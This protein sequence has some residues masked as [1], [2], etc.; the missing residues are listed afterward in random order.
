M[1]VSVTVETSRIYLSGTGDLTLDELNTAVGDTAVMERTGTSPNYVYEIKG[2]RELEGRNGVNFII[3]ED[4]TLEWDLSINKSPLVDF[5]TGSTFTVEPGVTIN[6]DTSNGQYARMYFY[7]NSNFQGTEAKPIIIKRYYEQRIYPRESY[8]HNWNWV[9]FQD[10]SSYSLYNT[11]LYFMQDSDSNVVGSFTN[12]KFNN[13]TNTGY[14]FRFRSTDMSNAVFDNILVE[15]CRYAFE[16]YGSSFKFTNSTFKN[17]Y[18]YNI[19]N[20]NYAGNSYVISGDTSAPYNA[21][22]SKITFDNCTFQDNYD[23]SSTTRGFYL[24]YQTVIKFKDCTFA[25]VD[26]TLDYGA[27]AYYSSRFLWEGSSTFT[28]VSTY[29]TWST[30]STH[31]HVR[32]LDLTVNDSSG[33][34]LANANVSIRQKEGKEVWNFQT[35]SSGKI[36]DLFGDLPVFVE[37]NETSTGNFTNWSDGTGD[38]IHIITISHPDYQID[39]REV[40]FTQDRVIVAQLSENAPGVTKL[41]DSTIYDSTIY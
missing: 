7:G 25:G 8:T 24:T 32:S 38:K 37:K 12:L 16:T 27:Q 5:Q 23:A 17:I 29:R 34:P 3:E 2:N 20:G 13:R 1:A 41:Y 18:Y 22:Q 40:A 14:A 9:E 4:Q 6:H 31:L 15:E 19:V 28:N 39:T 36:K 33:S 11:G 26:S 21:V 30:N 35:D 10:P